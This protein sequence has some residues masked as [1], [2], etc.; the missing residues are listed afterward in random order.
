M[1]G[2]AIVLALAAAVLTSAGDEDPGGG[3][4]TTSPVSERGLCLPLLGWT[5]Q[6][7]PSCWRP[8]ADASPFNRELPE[9]PRLHPRSEQI[10]E[11]LVGF[12]PLQ[13]LLAGQAGTDADFGRPTYHSSSDD[14]LFT[15]RCRAT[16]CEL[17]GMR[18]RIP[19]RAQPA[20]GSDAHM[21][22][23]DRRGGWEYDLW[24]VTQKPRGGG[25]VSLARGGRTRLDGLGLGS[26][27][28]AAQWGNL[29]GIVR[30]EELAAGEIDHALLIVVNCDSGEHVYPADGTG[31]SCSDIGLPDED[32]PAMG[33]RFVLDMT[34]AEIDALGVPRWKRAILRAVARYGM[35]VGDTGGTTWSI[36]EESGASYTSLGEEDRWVQFAK[37]AGVPYFGPDATWVF[38]VQSDVDWAERLRVVQPCEARGA[39][40]S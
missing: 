37:R 1:A 10:V 12:G 31:R 6:W 8:Y 34:D 39:C 7:P 27:A 14:P 19:D 25:T 28:V 40:G 17:E 9:Q 30:A 38:D 3:Q 21:T 29:G 33:A 15:V 32:A 2:V 26:S 35:Y 13:N 11:R 23:I 20:G 22:V 18:I 4:P 24:R 16:P 36:K 5:G